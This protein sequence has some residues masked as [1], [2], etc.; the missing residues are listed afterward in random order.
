[1]L[2]RDVDRRRSAV[3]ELAPVSV[4]SVVVRWC[5]V[6]AR[7]LSKCDAS[8][9]MRADARWLASSATWLHPSSEAEGDRCPDRRVDAEDQPMGM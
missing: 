4:C 3:L 8:P 1:M 2:N 6:R 5:S 7:L 9:V